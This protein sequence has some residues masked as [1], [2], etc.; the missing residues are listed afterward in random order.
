MDYIAFPYDFYFLLLWLSLFKNNDAFITFIFVHF[1][2][3]NKIAHIGIFIYL[4]KLS[5]ELKLVV[6]GHFLL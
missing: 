6:D 2:S 3:F 5:L 4:I 1:L